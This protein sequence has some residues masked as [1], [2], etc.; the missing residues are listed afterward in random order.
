[1]VVGKGW[2]HRLAVMVL[3]LAV[4][5]ATAYAQVPFSAPKNLSN[6]SDFSFTPQVAVDSAGNIYVVWEDDTDTNSNILFSRSTDGGA[7]FSTPES[8]SQTSGLSF[9]PRIA[10]DTQG[11]INVVWEDDSPG[12]LDVFFSRSTD[13][14][15]T[16]SSP[17]NLSTDAADSAS[18][19]VA[20]D[21]AGNIFVVWENDTPSSLGILFSR[22]TNGGLSFTA[23]AF[24]STNMGGSVSPQM[25]VDLGGNIDVVWEDDSVGTADISYSR[26]ANS[27]LSFSVPKSLS[28]NVGNSFNAHIA[29]D[30]G[31]HINVVWENDSPG[32]FDIFYSRSADNGETFSI[33]KNLSNDPGHSR[34]PQ[35]AVDLSGSVNVLWADNVPPNVNTDVFFV[36]SSDGGATFSAVRNLSNNPGSSANA[37]LTVDAGGTVNVTWEDNTPGNKDILF[38]RSTDGAATFSAPQNLSNDQGLSSFAQVAADKNANL[39]LVWQ[40]ATPGVS[41]IFFSRFSSGVANRPP[42]ADAGLDQNVQSDGSGGAFVQLNGSK[43]SDPDGDVLTYLWKD[44]TGNALGSAAIVQLTLSTGTH[45]FTLT[46]TDPGGLS[47]TATT[48]VTVAAVNRPPIANAGPDQTIR[49]AGP[50]GTQATLNGSGSSDPDGDVL[51]YVWKDQWGNVVGRTAVVQLTVRVGT[52][53]FTLTVTDPGGLSSTATTQVTVQDTTSPTLQLSLSPSSLWPPNHKLVQITATVSASDSCT[54]HPK[55]QLSS[56]TSS[57]PDEGQGDGDQPNDVQ[58]ADGGAV[59]FGTDVRSFLLRAER[60]GMN[61]GR[62]YTVTYTARDASGNTSSAS[63]QVLVGDGPSDTTLRRKLREQQDQAEN[64]EHRAHDKDQNRDGDKDHDNGKGRGDNHKDR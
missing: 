12:N 36:R 30:L 23:P 1:M 37:W 11:G 15:T 43:S 55:I 54:S 28:R 10:V 32:N 40:D 48:R 63:A 27:G 50:T 7:T 5:T 9:N 58:A 8:L 34:N 42:F 41:Q 47:S 29:V 52:S 2:S 17:I 44:E 22:S 35:I 6:N 51:T 25:L 13:G 39:N 20:A 59:P 18:P 33:P 3:G 24:L 16:F 38:A 49:C 45:T 31:G 56:I 46:V 57:D 4:M 60:S 21:A 14:G 53:T 19:Q 26:S 61:S 62:V 64:F